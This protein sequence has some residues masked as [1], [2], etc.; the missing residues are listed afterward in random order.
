VFFARN[1]H[2]LFIKKKKLL[3]QDSIPLKENEYIWGGGEGMVSHV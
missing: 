3:F 2:E 1:K